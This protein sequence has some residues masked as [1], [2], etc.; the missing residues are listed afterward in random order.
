MPETLSWEEVDGGSY[1]LYRAFDGETV[2]QKRSLDAL[3]K[4]ARTLAQIQVATAAAPAV[5]KASLPHLPVETIPNMFAE[6]LDNIRARYTTVW[7]ADDGTLSQWM[8]FAAFEVLTRL[9]SMQEQIEAWS[10]ELASGEW[11][12]SIVHGDLH[13]GNAVVQ[14]DGSILIFD[15]DDA[16]LSHP[17]MSIEPLLVG[18]WH[19]D[20]NGGPGPWGYVVGTPSQAA[21]RDAYLDALPWGTRAERER[22][23]D[24][25]MCLAV[26]KE[27]HHEWQWAEIMG[28]KNGN[29]EWTAQLI[30]RL[31]Q[32]V[33]QIENR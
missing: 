1:L 33:A 10:R 11:P 9:E 7:A 28:W 29:P 25:A 21:V 14:A 22:A 12:L 13:S 16:V 8:P 20:T 6:M 15:W 19:L 5:E 3:T 2:E 18:A 26:V 17:F 32:H 30:S 27:M 31:W 4:T 24:V 23:F